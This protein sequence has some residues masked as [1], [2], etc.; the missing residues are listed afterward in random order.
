M[1][2]KKFVA[3]LI[4]LCLG[5]PIPL[6]A[7]EQKKAL[8]GLKGVKVTVQYFNLDLDRILLPRSELEADIEKKLKKLSVPVFKLPRPPAMSTLFININIIKGKPR[9]LI[10]YSVSV[11]LMEWAYLKRDIGSVGDLM[12][13]R[14]IN[15][16][17]GKVG[18]LQTR[19][20]RDILKITD[21]LVQN[22]IYDYLAANRE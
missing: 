20:A 6:R 21:N 7:Y 17:E 19:S 12:E 1:K 13:V 5:W 18:Y 8:R 2:V 15:W 11:V 10:V 16:Y 14:A 9:G 3:I 4:V 22:F